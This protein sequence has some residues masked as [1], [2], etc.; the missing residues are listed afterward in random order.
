MNP[1]CLHLKDRGGVKGGV[2]CL[3]HN[4]DKFT[5]CSFRCK[6][7]LPLLTILKDLS[8]I[9]EVFQ[10]VKQYLELPD[11]WNYEQGMVAG[12]ALSPILGALY[13]LPLDIAMQKFAKAGIRYQG[14]VI[15]LAKDR[16][17]FR[18]V[19]K[20]MYKIIEPLGLQ[21]YTEEKRFIGRIEKGFDFLEYQF[22]RGHKLRPSMP[23]LKRFENTARRLYEGGAD[24]SRIFKY[25]V[26]WTRY[27]FGDLALS[28]QEKV[29]SKN[30]LLRV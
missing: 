7:L 10:I 24:C 1:H 3:S 21:M 14:N 29:A 23:S 22:N 17:M 16:P 12:G 13:L 6:I 30:T 27:I 26:H 25:V 4:L 8:I 9:D 15:I 18:E 2:R 20:T 5:C 28:Y 11:I 19:I